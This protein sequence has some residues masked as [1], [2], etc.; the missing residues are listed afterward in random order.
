MSLV[1]HDQREPTRRGSN[2][3]C[4][5]IARNLHSSSND[6]VGSEESH[7]RKEGGSEM[8]LGEGFRMDCQVMVK[9]DGERFWEMEFFGLLICV[10]CLIYYQWGSRRA[11]IDIY[12]FFLRS[13]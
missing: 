4:V 7:S 1:L 8:H 10:V 3:N 11:C 9:S 2:L 5:Y 6:L 12:S 13:T